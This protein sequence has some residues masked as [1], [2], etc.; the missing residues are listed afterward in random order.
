MP[1]LSA[2]R[3][4]RTRSLAT[5]LTLGALLVP[6]VGF[7]A[8]VSVAV[9]G[10]TVE[11]RVASETVGDVLA[12]L[13]V[14]VGPHD[15][16]LPDPRTPVIEGL[17][18]SIERAIALD[19]VS[20]TGTFSRVVAPVRTVAEAVALAGLTDAQAAGA[21]A[22]P[23]WD[24]RP[25]AGEVVR[26]RYPVTV[27]IVADGERRE[28]SSTLPDVAAVLEAEGIALR[29]TDRIEPAADT[30]L[31]G[32]PIEVVIE[33]IDSGEVTVSTVLERRLVIRKDQTLDLGVTRVEQEGRQGQRV[34]TFMVT[35][36][37]GAEESRVLLTSVVEVEP[38]D[39]IVIYGTRITPESAVWDQLAWCESRGN[40]S[41]D[42]PLFDGGLQFH[43]TTWTSYK[44]P[45]DPQYAYQATREQQILVAMRVQASQGW[46]A[47]PT[48]ARIIG[49][50]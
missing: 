50:L 31:V 22:T 44:Y 42:G 9:D 16:V 27:T 30:P 47:W 49:L 45:G 43:P 21:V 24:A 46:K 7:T 14:P 48:C 4:G 8:K 26:V 13:E 37:D 3:P 11:G 18:I 19:V 17:Q 40:W 39:R 36:V 6:V 34:D 35:Y 23:G 28:V 5:L 10:A 32:E 15:R 12:D 29:D 1:P 2:A 38:E 20:N 41:I 25:V 33:R